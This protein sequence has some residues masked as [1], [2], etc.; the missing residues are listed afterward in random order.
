MMRSMNLGVKW[1]TFAPYKT[2]EF[3]P[4]DEIV[5]AAS[6]KVAVPLAH[7]NPNLSSLCHLD[8]RRRHRQPSK[9]ILPVH[10]EL[11]FFRLRI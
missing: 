5:C 3:V 7:R 2:P 10:S 11:I 9:V 6:S 1:Y 8:V 4:I